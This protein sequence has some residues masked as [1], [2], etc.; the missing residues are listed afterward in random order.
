VNFQKSTRYALYAAMELARAKDG[1]QVTVAQVAER[2]TIPGAVL[3]KVFPQLVRA[4]VAVGTRGTGGGYQLARKAGDVTL[5]DV[6]D[7]FEPSGTPGGCLLADAN[8]DR[9]NLFPECELREVV[10]EVDELVR[11]T[12][13]SITLETLVNRRRPNE[14]RPSSDAPA[15]KEITGP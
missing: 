12:F 7:A 2:Y 10:D 1:D 3:A 5:L 9:C 11:C 6:I 4:G 15:G 14:P 13:A 8:D